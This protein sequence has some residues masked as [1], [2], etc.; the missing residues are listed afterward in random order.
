MGSRARHSLMAE[1]PTYSSGRSRLIA[2]C[3]VVDVSRVALNPM[4]N[5]PCLTGLS[6]RL[7]V[8][9]PLAYVKSVR[10]SSGKE[11]S[12]ARRRKIPGLGA[13]L[14]EFLPLVA[15]YRKAPT[16]SSQ[17]PM[18]LTNQMTPRG[19]RYVGGQ[20]MKEVIVRGSRGRE[21]R[22]LVIARDG[23]RQ[24]SAAWPGESVQAFRQRVCAEA[25]AEDA[26]TVMFFGLP[27]TVSAST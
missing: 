6:Y 10:R 15:G 16:L 20:Q 5:A 2:F 14:R 23:S 18:M 13:D 3:E 1:W 11:L 4:R 24:E 9:G 19:N 17:I 12:C 25:A 7:S 26:D 27:A 8:M 22:A 21:P